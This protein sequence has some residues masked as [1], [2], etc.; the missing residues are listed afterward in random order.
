MPALG[1]SRSIRRL[2]P[3]QRLTSQAAPCFVF[4][5]GGTGGHLFPG[6]AVAAELVMRVPRASIVF[7]GPGRDWERR[8]VERAGFDYLRIPARPLSRSPVQLVPSVCHNIVG[9]RLMAGW[10][11]RHGVTGVIGLGGYSSVPA[12]LAARRRAIPTFLLEQNVVPGK[13]TRWLAP[14]AKA[15]FT[16]FDETR[17]MLRSTARVHCTGNPVRHEIAQLS[18][19]VR[20]E[21]ERPTLLVT[22][23]SQ[24]AQSLN[25]AVLAALAQL[26][27]LGDRWQIIH[28]TGPRDYDDAL[29]QY[30]QLRIRARVR[31]FFEEMAP[32]YG[33]A[34]LAVCRAG[35]TTLS[36]L[37]CAGLPAI[38]LPYP[39]AAADH[40]TAN[41][42][43]YEQRGA[44]VCIR[45]R[46]DVRQTT[47]DLVQ[48][49]RALIA[50]S[51]RLGEQAARMQQLARTQAA[52]EVVTQVILNTKV[53]V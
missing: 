28:Q 16:A 51:R 10:L 21:A 1:T 35:A 15:V 9:Y 11:G 26:T 25:R 49:L 40:Q 4:A 20:P 6:L 36:E 46:S 3:A 19:R 38:V 52:S 53:P 47:I 32:L 29:R 37:A 48:T 14:G 45:D 31:P 33:Q 23:G 12:T 39:H 22:G 30:E 8:C 27:D 34:D 42:R 2:R 13:A 41:A 50:D 5:G 43:W 17:E 7:A 24:G 18:L 44:A